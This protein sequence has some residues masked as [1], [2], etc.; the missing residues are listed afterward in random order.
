MLERDPAAHG[1]GTETFVAQLG[2]EKNDPMSRGPAL[3][4]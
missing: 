1:S 2:S 3:S 4:L